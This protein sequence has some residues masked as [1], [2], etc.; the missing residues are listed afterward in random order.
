M[1]KLIIAVVAIILILILLYVFLPKV[2]NKYSKTPAE[3]EKE[4]FEKYNNKVKR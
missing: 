4:L 2:V 1:V 3:K